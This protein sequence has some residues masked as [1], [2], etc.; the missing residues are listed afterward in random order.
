MRQP[1]ETQQMAKINSVRVGDV[2]QGIILS[3]QGYGGTAANGRKHPGAVAA[4]V[5]DSPSQSIATPL[6][7][8]AAAAA[9]RVTDAERGVAA[10]FFTGSCGERAAIVQ[11]EG[12]GT[13]LPA[14][15]LRA[16]ARVV[17]SG[18]VLSIP[19]VTTDAAA[20]W[21]A[22]ARAHVRAIAAVR[23][24]ANGQRGCLLVG[25][26]SPRR[27]PAPAI[28][29]LEGVA[30]STAL[31]IGTAQAVVSAEGRRLARELHD[32]F[33]QTLTS[34]ILAIDELEGTSWSA[35]HRLLT[36]AVRSYGL[37]AVRQIRE[38]L[39]TASRGIKG[40]DGRPHRI[41]DLLKELSHSGL[42]VHFRSDRGLG[43]LPPEVAECLYCVAREA[44]LNV[45]RHARAQRV[46][47]LVTRHEQEVELVVA[48]NG[49][50]FQEREVASGGWGSFGLR[51]MRERVE[52]IG[53]TFILQGGPGEG[54]RIT[55]RLPRAGRRPASSRLQGAGSSGR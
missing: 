15:V 24:V 46:D 36:R 48:D 17:R 29:R 4:E 7:R 38:L 32:T 44:L 39:D 9:A 5:Q 30:E 19:D 21:A 43:S 11:Q 37:K 14:A 53:G 45:S 1:Q 8:G 10:V 51:M 41:P 13:P 12:G 27:F 22:A 52:E 20:P 18:G 23:L 49:W 31:A 35:E 55:V 6:L 2:A 28:A 47:V 50:G 25:R 16:A 42:A 40:E 3:K 33:G 26:E 54:T 34:L